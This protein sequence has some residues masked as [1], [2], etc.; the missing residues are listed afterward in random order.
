MTS[1]RITKAQAQKFLTAVRKQCKAA[2]PTGSDLRGG[3][4][5]VK[6]WDWS[7]YGAAPWSIVWEEG[8][9]DWAILFPYGGI[10]EEF[11]CRVADVSANLPEGFYAEAITSWAVGLYAI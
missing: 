5:L 11:G 10:E 1:K 9:Y 8:P 4:T 7:G 3:P 6:D 2:L